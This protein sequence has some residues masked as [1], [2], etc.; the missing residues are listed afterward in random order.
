MNDLDPDIEARIDVILEK[1]ARYRREA[2]AFVMA[3]VTYTTRVLKREGHVTAAQLMNGI[4]R[5]GLEQ[6]GPMARTVFN[7]WGIEDS[8]QFGDLVFNLID[9]GLL[10]RRDEDRRSHFD[11]AAFDLERDLI[12]PDHG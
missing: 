4:R 6:F 7:Y 10:G 5:F 11:D 8:A 9:V 3:A 1:D 2:Y 12:D